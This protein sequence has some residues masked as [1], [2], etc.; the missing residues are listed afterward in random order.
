MSIPTTVPRL[1]PHFTAELHRWIRDSWRTT[2][3][4][5]SR[6]AAQLTIKLPH[7]YLVWPGQSAEP[8]WGGPD[9]RELSG[10]RPVDLSRQV[11]SSLRHS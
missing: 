8:S 3:L 4:L 6:L 11:F 9:M 5:Q 10:L 1:R 2:A 7:L